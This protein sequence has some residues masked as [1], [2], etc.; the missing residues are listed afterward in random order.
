LWIDLNQPRGRFAALILEPR[1]DS[2]LFRSAAFGHLVDA[3]ESLPVSR[4]PR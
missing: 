3:G 2:S 4:V 1:S